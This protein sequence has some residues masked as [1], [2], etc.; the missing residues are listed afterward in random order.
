M[1]HNARQSDNNIQLYVA[2]S[3]RVTPK[4]RPCR[5][6]TEDRADHADCADHVD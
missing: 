3:P 2:C 4:R 5:L 1:R 6:Q